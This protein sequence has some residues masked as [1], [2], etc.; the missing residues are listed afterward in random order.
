MWRN[1]RLAASNVTLPLLVIYRY[2]LLKNPKKET[3]LF[4]SLPLNAAIPQCFGI[5]HSVCLHCASTV[6]ATVLWFRKSLFFLVCFVLF[7]FL[8]F[9]SSLYIVLLVQLIGTV[10]TVP[11]VFFFLNIYVSQYIYC[12]IDATNFIIF[13]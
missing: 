8:S 9:L 5:V 2:K 11:K 13:S 10:A 1:M 12:Y 3:Q 4:M 7:V 6:A